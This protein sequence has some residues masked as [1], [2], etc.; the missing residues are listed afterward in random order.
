MNESRKIAVKIAIIYIVIGAFW[1][2]FSDRLSLILAHNEMRIFYFFQRYKGWFFILVTG[3][4]IYFLIYQRAS[5]LLES[6]EKLRKKEQQLQKSNQHYQSLF[7]HNPDAVFEITRTGNLVAL[8]PEGEEIIGYHVNDLK[9]ERLDFLVQPEER[10]EI[11][12]LFK[13]TLKG[14]PRKIR[15]DKSSI[16]T[17]RRNCFVV[18]S[19]PLL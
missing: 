2:I 19:C 13:E 1:V 4:L 9:G 12:A 3:I 11:R 10:E 15:N 18:H 7:K 17:A 5:R 14:K 6:T 8:N 16:K